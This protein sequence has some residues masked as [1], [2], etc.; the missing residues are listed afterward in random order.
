MTVQGSLHALRCKFFHTSLSN[1]IISWIPQSQFP[2]FH[3]PQNFHITP[4]KPYLKSFFSFLLNLNFNGEEIDTLWFFYFS[5]LLDF[6]FFFCV[7]LLFLEIS[8]GGVRLA[9]FSFKSFIFFVDCWNSRE[10]SWE[11]SFWY[12]CWILKEFLLQVEISRQ[13]L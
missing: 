11:V 7:A 9:G 12:W 1:G 5:L 6:W 8:L 3:P 10:L 2:P 4:T 13:L